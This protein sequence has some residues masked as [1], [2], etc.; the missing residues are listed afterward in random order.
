MKNFLSV[1]LLN[2]VSPIKSLR[3]IVGYLTLERLCLLNSEKLT[4]IGSVISLS[5]VSPE[6]HLLTQLYY[7]NLFTAC[8][9][10]PFSFF[11]SHIYIFYIDERA[12]YVVQLGPKF[13]M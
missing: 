1:S 11:L 7:I 13:N 12:Q 4:N 3:F 2:T 6:A 8:L 10:S 9:C 5:N